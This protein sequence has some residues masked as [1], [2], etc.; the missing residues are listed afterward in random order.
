MVERIYRTHRELDIAF[1]IDIVQNFQRDVRNILHVDVF[2]HHDD[3]LGEHRLPQ[4]P[5]GVHHFACLTRIGLA[6][7]NNHQVVKHAFD[8]HIQVY[9]FGDGQLHQ[10]QENALDRLPHPGIF[11]WRL[12]DDGRRID[13]IFAMR[14][15]G[16]VEDGIL[17]FERV[18][19]SVIAERPFGAELV[20]IH[21]ALQNN[22]GIGRNL[23]ID[24]LAFHQ[25][26]WLLPQ[27]SG[28]DEFFYVWR[29]W[30]DCG[31]SERRIGANRYRHIHF[32]CGAIAGS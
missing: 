3:A 24:G 27:E 4:R 21:V 14:H 2:I 32:A 12:A 17:V 22:L 16:D 8:R 1:G 28:D 9:Q 25:L 30:D 19:A 15:A 5:D 11:L 23:Q 26:D 6:N 10:R 29:R 31:K 20:Q 18:K 13:R 7:G